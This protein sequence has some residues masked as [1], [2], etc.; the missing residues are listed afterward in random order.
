MKIRILQNFNGLVD[1]RSIPFRAGQ[2]VE[3]TD[4]DALDNFLRGGYAE[5]L[6]PAVKVV[7]KPQHAKGIKVK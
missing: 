4:P 3:I 7:E 1:G 6:K 5:L 2:E